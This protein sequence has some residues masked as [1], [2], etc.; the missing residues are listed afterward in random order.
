MNNNAFGDN[1]QSNDNLRIEFE[2]MQQDYEETKKKLSDM[3]NEF[4]KFK[5]LFEKHGHTG[6]DESVRLT[7]TIELKEGT[8]MKTGCVSLQGISEKE[9][10]DSNLIGAFIVGND[11]NAADGSENTQLI[12]QHAKGSLNSFF[13]GNRKP[14]YQGS[15]GSITSGGTTLAQTNYNWTTNELAGAF[16]YVNTTATEFDFYEI[17]SNTASTITITG[18]T[19]TATVSTPYW[20]IFMPVYLGSSQF[21][22][23]RVYTM[24]GSTGGIRF[25]GGDTNGGQNALLY[26]DGTDLKFRKKDGTVTTVTVV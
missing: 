6:L 15:T 17:A 16:I 2:I 14:L 11:I 19:W 8:Y 12:V 5:T 18:G 4:A 21:P 24:D 10:N 25:G 7:D 13:Y 20:F 9:R 22:W 23:R 26:T 1:Q 3:E